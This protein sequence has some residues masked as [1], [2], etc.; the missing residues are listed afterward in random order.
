MGNVNKFG[1]RTLQLV[2]Q[3]GCS[4]ECG[5]QIPIN[6][7][8]PLPCKEWSDMESAL[9]RMLALEDEQL[10]ASG[11]VTKVDRSN[12]AD[13]LRIKKSWLDVGD[14]QT[15]D[16][17]QPGKDEC[18]FNY[19]GITYDDF[20]KTFY[21][22]NT[23][24]HLKMCPK[25]LIGTKLQ[26]FIGEGLSDFNSE[27]FADTDLA[28]VLI[29]QIIEKYRKEFVAKFVLLSVWEGAAENQHG[30][31]GVL[32][33][34][35]YQHKNQFFET[36]EYDLSAIVSGDSLNAI[37]GGAQYS[38][39]FDTFGTLTGLISDFVDWLNSL[40]DRRQPIFNASFDDATFAVVVAANCVTQKIDLRIVVN[41]G[42]PVDWG[43][44]TCTRD[45]ETAPVCLQNVMPIND[46]PLMFKFEE[47]TEANFATLF[48]K[49]IKEFVRYMHRNGFDGVTMD[50]IMIGIDPELMLERND[51]IN[52]RII[53]GGVQSDFMDLIG[54]SVDKFKPLNALS[55]TGLFFMTVPGNI[56]VFDDAANDANG[57]PGR[58][59]VRIKEECDD[60]VAIIFDNPLG[61]AVE[62]GGLFAANLCDSWFVNDNDLDNR[63][64]YENT[65]GVLSCYDDSNR[66]ACILGEANCTV[67]ASV[68]SVA[69]YDA[70]ADETSITVTV[71]A[72]S[73]DPAL[74]LTYDLAYTTSEGTAD[75]AITTS[76]FVIT[77]PGDQTDSGI[78]VTV[79]GYVSAENGASEV[80]C[81]QYITDTEKL[82]EG[83]GEVNCT[84]AAVGAGTETTAISLQYVVNGGAPIVVA[85]VDALL[86]L[87]NA[88]DYPA[89]EAEIEAILP[90]VTA[91][92]VDAAGSP[93]VTLTDV[94]SFIDDGIELQTAGTDL[95]LVRDC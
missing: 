40:M 2:S 19:E 7:G 87:S 20:E 95:V 77:L 10:F 9:L 30:D 31:D 75:D 32:A 91:T 11:F 92:V 86:D 53:Q 14:I 8:L 34:M 26:D 88:A 1:L 85:F 25:N 89:I 21:T 22:V 27:N 94:P 18:K 84:Q 5:L 17:G 38:E 44:S 66:K 35:W 54:L 13:N 45:L 71:T 50:S 79:Y 28:D 3:V 58:G 74:T 68:A 80:Q 72:F 60:Q 90:G 61:S 67:T 48:K 70:G 81:R 49:Y 23:G 64:P 46:T 43:G 47:I 37:V 36:Y 56:L 65:R 15:Q 82:G 42:M 76:S 63:Q 6:N 69:A 4:D 29:T 24:K 83:T 73:S 41:Q 33:K 16:S 93:D 59:R 52:C 78:V 57:M 51:A 12:L 55:G 39:A 62:H